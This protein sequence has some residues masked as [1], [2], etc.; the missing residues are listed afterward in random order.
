MSSLGL[1][2]LSMYL[3]KNK[4]KLKIFLFSEIKYIKIVK[5]EPIN[6]NLHS[7]RYFRIKYL[8]TLFCIIHMNTILNK[9]YNK[10]I[11]VNYII[12]TRKTTIFYPF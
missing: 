6:A 3:L 1:N 8:Y 4:F 10:H 9:W 7:T 2:I 5:K 12:L 11:I